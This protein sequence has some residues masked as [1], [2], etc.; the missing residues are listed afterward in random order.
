M[1]VL[2]NDEVHWV[3]NSYTLQSPKNTSSVQTRKRKSCDNEE[4]IYI[5]VN[6]SNNYYIRRE[7][8][9]KAMHCTK[10][11]VD[12]ESGVYDSLSTMIEHNLLS[13]TN[14][15]SV[16]WKVSYETGSK[17]SYIVKNVEKVFEDGI[18]VKIRGNE[19]RHF[20]FNKLH[21]ACGDGL[22]YD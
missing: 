11:N 18:L 8:A 1:L 21:E 5:I 15:S 17:D 4:E 10:I 3:V 2:F 12:I 20:K 22:E 16:D 19:Y 6:C 13:S 7:F 14:T 9:V